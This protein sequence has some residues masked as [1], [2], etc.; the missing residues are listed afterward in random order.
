MGAS[1]DGGRL[2]RFGRR[3]GFGSRSPRFTI[4]APTVEGSQ[5]REGFRFP[6]RV[7]R[8]TA[9]RPRTKRSEAINLYYLWTVER[10]GVLYK[11]RDISGKD[12]YRW[13]AEL[14]LDHQT[15]DGSWM[16]GNYPGSMPITDT[17]FALLFLKRANLAKELTKKLEFFT[18][19]KELQT[20]P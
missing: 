13:G 10:C 14:L 7:D 8:Q 5:H 1:H 4:Q 18:E 9:Q 11:R 16:A 19:N 20:G 15:A 6:G 2:A 17:C 3:V 12:W